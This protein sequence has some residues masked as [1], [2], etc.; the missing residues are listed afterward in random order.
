VINRERVKEEGGER[1]KERK[2][3]E[4]KKKSKKNACKIEINK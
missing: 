2:H 1:K 4:R 3:T